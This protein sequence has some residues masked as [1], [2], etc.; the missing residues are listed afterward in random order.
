[1]EE[2]SDMDYRVRVTPSGSGSGNFFARHR[3]RRPG[4]SL[5]LGAIAPRTILRILAREAAWIESAQASCRGRRAPP[6]AAA[7]PA[8]ATASGD[9]LAGRRCTLA[10]NTQPRGRTRRRPRDR[11]QSDA[12]AFSGPFARLRRGVPPRSAPP[13]PLAVRKGQD[14]LPAPGWRM[15]SQGWQPSRLPEYGLRR[16]SSRW[17]ELPPALVS[18]P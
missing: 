16:S 10:V 7:A 13:P 4:G 2:L 11:V 12:L 1:M 9:L 6:G 17:G 18:S 15:W 8:C 5:P 3:H 14:H